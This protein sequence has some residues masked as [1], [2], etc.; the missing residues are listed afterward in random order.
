MSQYS[1]KPSGILDSDQIYE[2]NGFT[3]QQCS[4]FHTYMYV[5]NFFWGG[6][7]GQVP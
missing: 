7:G 6:G 2:C 1:H 3:L 4:C 5:C